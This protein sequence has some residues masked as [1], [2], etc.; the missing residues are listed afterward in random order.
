MASDSSSGAPLRRHKSVG[1]SHDAFSGSPH[2]A[3]IASFAAGTVQA[4]MLLPINTIQTQMQARGGGALT[5]FL[6]NFEHGMLSGLRN[7]YRA[8][9][10]TVFMLGARQGVKFGSGAFYKQQLPL[11]W[12]EMARDAV[13]GAASAC[14]GTTLLYPLDTLKT[15][16]QLGLPAPL[17]SQ[18]YYGF[19]PAVC[20]SSSGSMPTRLERRLEERICCTA[21]SHLPVPHPRPFRAPLYRRS[22]A[23]DCQSQRVGAQHAGAPGVLA[24]LETFPM[25]RHSGVRCAGDAD[26]PRGLPA[27][28]ARQG[29]ICRRATNAALV[30]RSPR[31]SLARLCSPRRASLRCASQIPTFPFDTL[32]KRL[33]SVEVP[34]SS[35]EEARVLLAQ[36]GPFR[37]Y[38]GFWVKCLFVSLN[39]AVFNTVFVAV[40]RMLRM[41]D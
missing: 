26:E 15:R 25:R 19:L 29:T 36:G 6:S 31:R 1:S 9:G 32:K 21:A 16:Y 23:L 41:Q 39:G 10:P 30:R 4:T 17:L 34:R 18:V 28:A 22:G 13:A 14:T 37:F 11:E 38:R 8:L 27:K 40:R 5:T 20:Y 3:A 2:R 24:L 35:L 12:P 33:Q 7:L